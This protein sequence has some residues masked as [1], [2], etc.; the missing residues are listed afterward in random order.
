MLTSPHV[1]QLFALWQ[2]LRLLVLLVIVLSAC[3]RLL[4]ILLLS[5]F[6]SCGSFLRFRSTAAIHLSRL[7]ISIDQNWSG[8]APLPLQFAH[9]LRLS[10]RSQHVETAHEALHLGVYVFLRLRYP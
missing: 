8:V 10:G 9:I 4:A 5:I 1:F 7:V 2:L 3:R 6:I